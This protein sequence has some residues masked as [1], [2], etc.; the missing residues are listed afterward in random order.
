MDYYKSERDVD[1]GPVKTAKV[2]EKKPKRIKLKPG[3]VIAAALVTGSLMLIAAMIIFF[4]GF[5]PI[6]S[7]MKGPSLEY[8]EM[9]MNGKELKLTPAD[10]FEVSYRD[11]FV[12]KKVRTDSLLS[13][14]ISA[15]VEGTGS[16]N[17]IGTLLKGVELVDRAIAESKSGST[18]ASYAIK[19]RKDDKV[20]GEIPVK[21]NITPQDWLRLAKG[22]EEGK[23]QVEYLKKAL[24]SN[25]DD[26]A[27]RKMLAAS[28][29][30]QGKRP[31][32]ISEYQAV[33]K[34]KPNDLPTLIELS[35]IY[36]DQKNY[37]DAIPVFRKIAGAES[38]G[39]LCPG[40]PGPVLRKNR[41]H[42]GGGLQLLR[43][44]EDH[45]PTSPS[46]CTWRNFTTGWGNRRK[47]SPNTGKLTRK[48]QMIR[49]S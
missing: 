15:D 31:N 30:K 44:P 33:L 10:T 5:N 43:V 19:V 41:Q 27:T 17:D 29:A 22:S 16:E 2:P 37:K 8:L 40:K 49:A 36:L 9:E 4:P 38:Q 25:K 28:Y 13:R 46:G 39:R 7:L 3:V 23:S 24:D 11:E 21:V 26:V 34:I 14:N 47:Q 20:I 6:K 45:L 18:Y 32:A 12:I 35:K 42:E 1:S 48:N